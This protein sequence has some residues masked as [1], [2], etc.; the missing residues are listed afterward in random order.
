MRHERRQ[1]L[2]WTVPQR[3]GMWR[4]R[5]PRGQGEQSLW[6]VQPGVEAATERAAELEMEKAERG[7][8]DL[9]R[10]RVDDLRLRVDDELRQQEIRALQESLWRASTSI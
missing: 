5:G 8:R 9:L 1:T 6:R 4:Q 7:M 2:S 3:E 10:H